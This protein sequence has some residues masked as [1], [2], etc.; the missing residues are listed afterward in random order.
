MA[1]T[2]DGKQYDEKTLSPELQNYLAVRQEIQVSK[3]RHTIEI[4]K[5]DVLTK[6][7][8]EKIIGLIKKEVPETNKITDKK[9]MA[10]IANLTIDQGATFT[11][12]VTVKDAQ[13]N[14]F[15]LT[16]YTAVAKLAKGFASTKTRTNMTTSIATDATTGVVTLSL[17][18]TETSALD[19]ERYVYDL[20]I[21]SGATVTRVI[22]GIITVRAQVTL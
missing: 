7:Y 1:I 14:A 4:E 8:N 11:S 2:I 6:F 21:T 5:I 3:T 16:G 22:E 9:Q 20:E 12:D 15:N 19:A 17:T 13:G 10:A 18:A